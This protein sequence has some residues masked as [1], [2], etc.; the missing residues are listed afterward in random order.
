LRSSWDGWI[1]A[2][3]LGEYFDFEAKPTRH[4]RF[5]F[6]VDDVGTRGWREMEGECQVYPSETLAKMLL[7]QVVSRAL[8][9]G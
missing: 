2:R 4:W 8:G 1:A 9:Q 3:D 6:D 7:T 5:A